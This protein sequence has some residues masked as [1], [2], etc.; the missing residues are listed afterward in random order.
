M[1]LKS[2]RRYTL[3]LIIIIG[4]L[5]WYIGHQVSTYEFFESNSKIT[6]HNWWG[7]VEPFEQS[8]FETLFA[9]Y[10]D[11]YDEIQIYSVFGFTGIKE[12]TSGSIL[13]VQYSGE[14]DYNTPELFD[15]NIIPSKYTTIPL[16]LMFLYIWKLNIPVSRLLKPRKL[17]KQASKFCLFSVSNG[18]ANERVDFFNQLSNY[19]QVD[20]CGKYLNNLGHTCPGGHSSPEYYEFISNYKFMICFENTS[21]INYLTEKLL[22]AYIGG[23]IPIYWGCP[24]VDNYV[25]TN[26]M[27]YLPPNYSQN[28]VKQLIDTILRLDTDDQAYKEKYEQPFLVDRPELDMTYLQQK[29]YR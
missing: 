20:S 26:C 15:I 6:F 18:N 28:D 22:N 5:L 19:K 14:S 23:T 16:P 4:I 11:T 9:K 1:V 2:Y 13:K 29:I 21:K 27:L 17:E 7:S 25:N 10:M 12:P 3:L 8:Y 24:N